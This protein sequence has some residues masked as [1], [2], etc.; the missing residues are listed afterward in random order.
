MGLGSSELLWVVPVGPTWWRLHRVTRLRPH[1]A[2]RPQT[3]GNMSA[4]QT[5][6]ALAGHWLLTPKGSR[7]RPPPAAH[8]KLQGA[9]GATLA[10]DDDAAVAPQQRRAVAAR[11]D[12][13]LPPPRRSEHVAEERGPAPLGQRQ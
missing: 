12:L 6:P 11:E 10:P 7:W 5:R 3:L 1:L 13:R 9:A 2:S 8:A 4:P